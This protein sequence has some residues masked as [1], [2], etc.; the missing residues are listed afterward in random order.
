MTLQCNSCGGTYPDTSQPGSVT[1]FH[2]C[3]DK[4][5]ETPEVTDKKGNI[6]TPA[7]FIATPNPRNENLKPHPEKRGE[8]LMVSEGLGITKLEEK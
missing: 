7:K 4:I 2:V 5:V 6:V 3:P 8:F 1:Y